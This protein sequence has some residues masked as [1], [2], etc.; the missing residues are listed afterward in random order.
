MFKALVQGVFKMKA[1]ALGMAFFASPVIGKAF[2]EYIDDTNKFKA[3][4]KK[5][6]ILN[7]GDLSKKLADKYGIGVGRGHKESDALQRGYCP[8]LFRDN[9]QDTRKVN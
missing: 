9:K 1:K 2:Q 4:L 8:K 5:Q 3:Q 6:G 7:Q